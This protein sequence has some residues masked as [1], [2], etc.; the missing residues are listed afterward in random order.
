[1][2]VFIS[3]SKDRSLHV[4]KA[5]YDWIPGVI[6]KVEPWLSAEI[7]KGIR[8]NAEVAKELDNSNFG[9]VCVT[10]ENQA[11]PWL[12]FEAGALAKSVTTAHVCVYLIDLK[13][14]DVVGPLKDFQHTRMDQEDTFRL[15]KTLNEAQGDDAL[16]EKRLEDA[17]STW[18]PRL[19]EQLRNLPASKI[20]A[21]ER[22]DQLSMIEEI[23]ASVRDLDRRN[24]ATGEQ[25][26]SLLSSMIL[27]RDRP[28]AVA[29]A[30]QVAQLRQESEEEKRRLLAEMDQ[31]LKKIKEELLAKKQDS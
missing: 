28:L 18:W 5:L 4:A 27:S 29:L 17:L 15:M 30:E 23:L 8:W 26:K 11:E 21:P 2:K 25:L 14:T 6:Q 24:A 31:Y 13:S 3:W 16:P 20:P 9:I 1:M 22:R 10:P 12:N 19:E 7:P